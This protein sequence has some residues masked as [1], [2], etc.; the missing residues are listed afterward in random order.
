MLEMFSNKLK[1]SSTFVRKSLYKIIASSRDRHPIDERGQ[2]AIKG[3]KSI[4]EK[5]KIRKIKDRDQWEVETTERT[6]LRYTEKDDAQRALKN[7]TD[8]LNEIEEIPEED[9]ESLKEETKEET[10]EASLEMLTSKTAGDYNDIK[11]W[12]GLRYDEKNKIW[13]VYITKRNIESFNTPEEALKFMQKSSNVDND[14]DKESEMQGDFMPIE[15]YHRNWTPDNC[16]RAKKPVN[17]SDPQIDTYRDF[18]YSGDTPPTYYFETGPGMTMDVDRYRPNELT[19]E[20][21]EPLGP[22]KKSY[23]FGSEPSMHQDDFDEVDELYAPAFNGHFKAI[24]KCAKCETL[25][26]PPVSNEQHRQQKDMA[27]NSLCFHC[28]HNMGSPGGFIYAYASNKPQSKKEA[29]L[30][31]LISD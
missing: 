13:E 18:E 20:P 3:V 24:G 4:D 31:M 17:V 28:G 26:F 8:P 5:K 23:Y 25:Y 6:N 19:M 15:R 12:K 2:D 9:I 22:K 30:V 1:K 11:T 27:A 29:M 16:P 14:V 7:V 10:T 21:D